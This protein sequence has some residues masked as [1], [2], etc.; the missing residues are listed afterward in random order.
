M[1][2]EERLQGFELRIV[3]D[4]ALR[5]GQYPQQSMPPDVYKIAQIWQGAHRGGDE[6]TR[7]MCLE[8]IM[9]LQGLFTDQ[10]STQGERGFL[11][12]GAA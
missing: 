12:G 2:S 7:R 4:S 9:N 3:R 1:E 11:P 6:E 8:Q 5:K 10:I